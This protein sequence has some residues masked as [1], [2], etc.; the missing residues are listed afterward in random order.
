MDG[1]VEAADAGNPD[2]LGRQLQFGH[3]LSVQLAILPIHVAIE[4]HREH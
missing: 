4:S 2:D 3:S 1:A